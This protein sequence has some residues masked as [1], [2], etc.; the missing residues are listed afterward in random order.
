LN[1]PNIPVSAAL[2]ADAGRAG[3]RIGQTAVPWAIGEI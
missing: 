3:R 1:L 2:V